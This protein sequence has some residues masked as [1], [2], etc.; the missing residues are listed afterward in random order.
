MGLLGEGINEIIATTRNNAAPIGIIVKDGSPKMVLFHGTHTLENIRSEGW[1]V[2]NIIHDPVI[3]VKTAFGDL[4][5]D[6]FCNETAGDMA[7][8]RLKHSSAWIVFKTEIE[9]DSGE[10]AIVRLVP[11][12]EEIIDNRIYP[13]NRGFNSIIE[14]TVHGTRY[15]M[16]RDP[17]LKQLIDHHASLVRKCGGSREKEAL[18][19]LFEYITE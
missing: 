8:K 7:V 1:V 17:Q 16:T 4:P 18:E 10:A 15:V 14:A 5:E 2:A 19:L 6:Y 12:A 11:V 13:V 9:R 3:Y